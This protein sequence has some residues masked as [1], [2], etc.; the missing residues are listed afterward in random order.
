VINRQIPRVQHHL[1]WIDAGALYC[2]VD[3]RVS[4]R[5]SPCSD[6]NKDEGGGDGEQTDLM[7]LG[8]LFVRATGRSSTQAKLT[9][10][11]QGV[12]L[13]GE[14]TSGRWRW[15][16]KVLKHRHYPTDGN[17]SEKRRAT[18]VDGDVG[19]V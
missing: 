5:P 8:L 12:R 1:K 10:M 11:R 13:L 16:E 15:T 14:R 6:A 17:W 4:G 18:I 19:V 9:R 3:T 7:H 2:S